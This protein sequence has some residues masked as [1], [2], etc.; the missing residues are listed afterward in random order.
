VSLGNENRSDATDLR[1]GQDP[2][3]PPVGPDDRPTI[4]AGDAL[5]SQDAERPGLLHEVTSSGGADNEASDASAPAGGT[6]EPSPPPVD[7]AH[8]PTIEPADALPT[9][10]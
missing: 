5:P 9:D 2:E 8:R 1:S 3:P 6:Q 4:D 7:P 10:A